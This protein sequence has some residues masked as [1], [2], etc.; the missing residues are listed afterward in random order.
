MSN[1]HENRP[2]D[3]TQRHKRKRS[4]LL[5]S[6]TKGTGAAAQ[7]RPASPTSA[8]TEQ[9]T[10]IERVAVDHR[11]AGC[12]LDVSISQRSKTRSGDEQGRPNVSAAN[13]HATLGFVGTSHGQSLQPSQSTPSSGRTFVL[14]VDPQTPSAIP[15]KTVAVSVL[16]VKFGEIHPFPRT[17]S[18]NS[19]NQLE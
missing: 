17:C 5:S 12:A 2:A 4:G 9:A 19:Q 14:L 15:G 1:G 8:G 13:G 7:D 10:E 16:P 3:E 11:R 6:K 18:K